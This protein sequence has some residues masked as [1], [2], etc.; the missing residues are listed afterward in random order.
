MWNE[1]VANIKDFFNQPI[2]IIGCTVAFA[3]VFILVIFS[4]TS[5]GKKLLKKLSIKIDVLLIAFANFKADTKAQLEEYKYHYE[6]YK[7]HYEEEKN[8]IE[9]KVAILEEVCLIIGENSHNEQVKKAMEQCKDKLSIVKTNYEELVEKRV[10]EE[11][12]KLEQKYKE[13][14]EEFYKGYLEQQKAKIE[15]LVSQAE[16]TV[17][18]AQ[19][20]AKTSI[21]DVVE[22]VENTKEQIEEVIENGGEETI[23]TREEEEINKD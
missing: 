16:K 8:K 10:K 5:L 6:E 15:E 19:N 12:D 14:Y 1:V 9:S 21:E 4:K 17:E 20:K 13:K 18:I 11:K 23:T 2:P 7:N 22:V 3:L